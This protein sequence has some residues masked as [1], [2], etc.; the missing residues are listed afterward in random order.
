MEIRDHGVWHRYKPDQPPP[1]APP[2]AMFS[3]REGDGVDW[4]AYVK[5]ASNF[6]VTSIKMT[7][8]G[9]IVGAAN[10][11]PTTLFPGDSNV[12]EVIGVTVD[13]PQKAVGGKAYDAA[14]KTFSDP[15][16]P[17]KRPDPLAE[18]LKR[19]EALEAK[20]GP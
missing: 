1:G 3:R 7:V 19:L 4:Y 13:D 18:I 12:I 16:P 5:D 17:V 20:K 6:D 14:S 8:V 10:V 2:N 11:D 15:P 9:G